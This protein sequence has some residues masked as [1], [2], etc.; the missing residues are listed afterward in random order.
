MSSATPDLERVE[1]D[2]AEGD[3]WGR[4]YFP[5]GSIEEWRKLIYGLNKH[6]GR[7]FEVLVIGCYSLAS[8]PRPS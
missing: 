2:D 6:L 8:Y 1:K 3:D 4:E 5:R 7:Y